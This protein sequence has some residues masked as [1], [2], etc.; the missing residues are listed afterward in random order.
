MD[1]FAALAD[2]TRRLIIEM[3]VKGERAAGAITDECG[4]SAPAVSQHLKTL[5][6]ARLVRVRPDGQHRFYSL[7]PTGLD[8]VDAWLQQVRR[9]WPGRLDALERE[10]TKPEATTSRGGSDD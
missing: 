5:R 2:P 6:D 10:L 4:A 8:A 9:F 7:D 1:R 3:L